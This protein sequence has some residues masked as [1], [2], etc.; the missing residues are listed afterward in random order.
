M[1]QKVEIEASI[2]KTGEVQLKVKGVK[3]S[4]CVDLSKLLTDELGEVVEQKK[5]PEYYQREQVHQRK[6]TR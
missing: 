1:A 5:T 2:T 3:G 6:T 4:K